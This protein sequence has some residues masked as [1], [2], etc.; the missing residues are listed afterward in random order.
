MMGLMAKGALGGILDA[1]KHKENMK[2]LGYKDAFVVAYKDGIRISVT[3][4][5]EAMKQK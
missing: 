2:K 3:E 4:A 5:M 1:K